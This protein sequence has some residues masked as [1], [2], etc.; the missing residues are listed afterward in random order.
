VVLDTYHGQPGE[1]NDTAG[2]QYTLEMRVEHVVDA[3]AE[4]LR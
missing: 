3:A 4:T 1:L 2:A